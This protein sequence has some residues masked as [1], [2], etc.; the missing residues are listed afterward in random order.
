VRFNEFL[1]CVGEVE[2]RSS[3]PLEL[4]EGD[5]CGD[6]LS[7]TR[8]LNSTPASASSMMSGRRERASAIEYRLGIQ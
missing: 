6:G 3:K 1:V 7:S 2:T 5:D 8:Q 4:A